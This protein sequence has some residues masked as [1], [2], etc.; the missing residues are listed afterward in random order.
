MNESRSS[1]GQKN[2]FIISK[3][4]QKNLL[5]DEIQHNFDDPN[6]YLSVNPNLII[7]NF[8]FKFYFKYF[9]K[10]SFHQKFFYSYKT[11]K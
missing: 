8:F 1:S 5:R 10:E 6:K 2:T 4:A 9:I 7:G 3:L 11:Q